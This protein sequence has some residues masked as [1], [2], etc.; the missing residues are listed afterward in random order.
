[1]FLTAYYVF[2]NFKIYNIKTDLLRY[3]IFLRTVSIFTLLMY[4]RNKM[5]AIQIIVMYFK[6]SKF[7]NNLFYFT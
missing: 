1:M 7:L 5:E 2:N 3:L 4:T 6:R